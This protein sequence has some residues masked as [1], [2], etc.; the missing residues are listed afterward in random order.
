MSR[1]MYEG[2]I[3]TDNAMKMAQRVENIK[4]ENRSILMESLYLLYLKIKEAENAA[5]LQP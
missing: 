4:P 3:T 1:G 2:T 5:T